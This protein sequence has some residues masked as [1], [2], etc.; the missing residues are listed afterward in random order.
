MVVAMTLCK[1]LL[2]VDKNDNIGD[3]PSSYYWQENGKLHLGDSGRQ[4]M[5][6]KYYHTIVY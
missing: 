2:Q 4:P 6:S 3:M 1:D 5:F